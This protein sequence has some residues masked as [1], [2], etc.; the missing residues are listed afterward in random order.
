MGA[1]RISW[2]QVWLRGLRGRCPGCGRGCLFTG[3]LRPAL[4]CTVCAVDFSQVESG[5]G[6]IFF[7]LFLSSIII[8]PLAVFSQFL[9]AYPLWL[10][11]CLWSFFFVFLMLL[12]LRM[13]KGVLIA[14][15]LTVRG[16]YDCDDVRL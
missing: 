10:L 1:L 15:Q 11:I 14:L 2:R 13:A 4:R 12:F 9:L 8:V 16:A 5:D 6:A 3:F 7:A